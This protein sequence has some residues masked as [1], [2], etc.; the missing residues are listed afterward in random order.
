MV[1]TPG[2]FV[3]VQVL[4]LHGRPVVPSGVIGSIQTVLTGVGTDIVFSTPSSP[5]E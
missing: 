4:P 5:E 3:V 1:C 2:R